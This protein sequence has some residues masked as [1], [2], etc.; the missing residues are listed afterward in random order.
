MLLFLELAVGFEV[1]CV[2]P[3]ANE[4]RYEPLA[5]YSMRHV[6]NGQELQSL[7]TGE[8][9][10]TELYILVN[11]TAT[12][13]CSFLV[14]ALTASTQRRHFIGIT[15]TAGITLM[16]PGNPFI[17]MMILHN[18][19]VNWVVTQSETFGVS[20]F[21]YMGCKME[22]GKLKNVDA[23]FVELWTDSPILTQFRS[24]ACGYLNVFARSWSLP[25]VFFVQS[26]YTLDWENPNP[27]VYVRIVLSDPV[28]EVTFKDYLVNI[29]RGTNKLFVTMAFKSPGNRFLIELEGATSCN[30][31]G[32]KGSTY[33]CHVTCRDVESCSL[34]DASWFDGVAIVGERAN[35]TIEGGTYIPSSITLKE[36]AYVECPSPLYITDLLEISGNCS[37]VLSSRDRVAVKTLSL[38]S[39]YLSATNIDYFFTDYF[40]VG[41]ES[42]GSSLIEPAIVVLKAVQPGTLDVVVEELNLW[43]HSSGLELVFDLSYS[44][45]KKPVEYCPVTVRNL[46]AFSKDVPVNVRF[47]YGL[48][49]NDVDLREFITLYSGQRCALLTYDNNVALDGYIVFNYYSVEDSYSTY[50]HGFTSANSFFQIGHKQSKNGNVMYVSI[51]GVYQSSSH[52]YLCISS[53]S[54]VCPTEVSYIWISETNVGA[55]VDYITERTTEISFVVEAKVAI[56]LSSLDPTRNY[57]L[58]FFS[59]SDRILD[60]TCT[61]E[62]AKAI[63]S[64]S[65]SRV[66][67]RLSGGSLKFA[68]D[69]LGIRTATF[70]NATQYIVSI[71][72]FMCNL[73]NVNDYRS[74][75][76]VSSV[77]WISDCEDVGEVAFLE[78]GWQMSMISDGKK[79]TISMSPEQSTPV[80]MLWPSGQATQYQILIQSDSGPKLT[81]YSSTQVPNTIAVIGNVTWPMFHMNG[82][83]NT[84]NL[85]F[86]KP[87]DE[88]PFEFDLSASATYSLSLSCQASGLNVSVPDSI[89]LVPKTTFTM[90]ADEHYNTVI[91]DE[92]VTLRGSNLDFGTSTSFIVHD[93]VAMGDP[94]EGN[95][96]LG[97]TIDHQITVSHD[98]LLQVT[99]SVI[100]QAEVIMQV[101]SPI[102]TPVIILN[103]CSL[104]KRI[105]VVHT[106]TDSQY[107]NDIRWYW[108]NLPPI[109]CWT[110]LEADAIMDATELEVIGSRNFYI[111]VSLG[112]SSGRQCLMLHRSYYRIWTVSV[113]SGF[114]VG[115]VFV[116]CAFAA[117]VF[118][119]SSQ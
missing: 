25:E 78:S 10:G 8:L 35:I 30:V 54:S 111:S 114:V 46:K 19:T 4:C 106:F 57:A 59:G 107:N 67:F 37:L 60:V 34:S 41:R 90:R 100:E 28:V 73:L 3:S 23:T 117:L 108:A 83:C 75:V 58:S 65:L 68:L 113:T 9:M 49:V 76:D 93:L 29:T 31:T 64:L 71:G 15:S 98:G 88:L 22:N 44:T 43:S 26:D 47:E 62:I 14:F 53:E 85:L 99:D 21:T 40:I 6:Q 7:I 80:R 51:E 89:S 72:E 74:L 91:F 110:G 55:W 16:I 18:L 5:E 69:F 42:R 118:K 1:I 96:F 13:Q 20:N 104:P 63:K 112:A 77:L 70:T 24:V 52:V 27:N 11:T 45:T 17:P 33:T 94:L 92:Q 95:E 105:R 102:D 103:N 50:Y 66:D 109:V 116:I 2:N 84:Y 48:L 79:T 81:F 32:T 101:D 12:A 97:G 86:A 38:K 119:C 36:G 39:G 82:T 115:T 56:D 87:F 61:A